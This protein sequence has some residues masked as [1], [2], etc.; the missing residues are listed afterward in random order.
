MS[1]MLRPGS[2]E[3]INERMVD[4]AWGVANGASES[5]RFVAAMP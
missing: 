2:K 1:E 3:I 4:Y 5:E